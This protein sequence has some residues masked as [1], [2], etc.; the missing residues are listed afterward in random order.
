MESSCC[1][2]G[3]AATPPEG[4]AQRCDRVWWPRVAFGVYRERAFG[5]ARAGERAY[6][7]AVVAR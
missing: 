6:D 1:A 5:H 3:W 7:N 2:C 4:L